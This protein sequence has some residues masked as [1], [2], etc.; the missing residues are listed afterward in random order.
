M[1]KVLLLSLA[2]LVS[3]VVAK[4]A[5]PATLKDA[6]AAVTKAKADVKTKTD[7]FDK[8]AAEK[9]VADDAAV[10][11]AKDALDKLK[12]PGDK[13]TKEELAKYKEEQG[14]LAAAYGEA[15][16][17]ASKKKT[18]ADVVAAKDAE[19]KAEA[20]VAG[21]YCDASK[22]AFPLFTEKDCTKAAT[23]AQKLPEGFVDAATGAP[24]AG[25][26]ACVKTG[27]DKG[28]KSVKVACEMKDSKATVTV[29]SY[30]DDACA[31]ELAK[32]ATATL[33]EGT[34][35]ANPAVP[36]TW[37]KI[38]PKAAPAAEEGGGVGLYI[39]IVVIVVVVCA[40][41]YFVKTK[42]FGAKAE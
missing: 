2:V 35:A 23:G 5:A 10:K 9:A 21:F 25:A 12:A 6:E 33:T 4:D 1:R 19:T 18:W 26:K 36:T 38:G 20:A 42:Y 28:T 31:D 30:T 3:L 27:S 14:K 41:L 17:T 29:T 24:K 32:D 40:A 22:L 8:E 37:I 39:L 34:C 7:A 11:K 15:V 13:A 16:D